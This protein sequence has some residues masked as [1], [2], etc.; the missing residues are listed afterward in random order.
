MRDVALIYAGTFTKANPSVRNIL[1][2]LRYLSTKVSSVAHH[3]QRPP[4]MR[5]LKLLRKKRTQKTT[6]KVD[7]IPSTLERLSRTADM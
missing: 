2:A 5:M 6:V 1:P 4:M 3:R 7:I